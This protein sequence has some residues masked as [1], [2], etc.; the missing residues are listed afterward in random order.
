[1]TVEKLLKGYLCDENIRKDLTDWYD[2]DYF[3]FKRI[4]A[5][6][7]LTMYMYEYYIGYW[8]VENF[9]TFAPFFQMTFQMPVVWCQERLVM[10]GEVSIGAYPS[11]PLGTV[12]RGQ[13]T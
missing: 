6:E 2:S 9:Q 8:K 7:P 12:P 5:Y 13:M 1:M 4:P 3:V 10:T 11:D